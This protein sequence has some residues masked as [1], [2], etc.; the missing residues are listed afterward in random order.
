VPNF[1]AGERLRRS[2]AHQPHYKRNG[3]PAKRV[4]T[5]E[6][7]NMIWNWVAGKQQIFEIDDNVLDD[8]L[9]KRD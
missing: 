2:K 8:K 5:Y 9:K 4:Q 3:C 1:G 6:S 7:K